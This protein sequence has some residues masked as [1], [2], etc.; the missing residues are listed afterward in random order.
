MAARIKTSDGENYIIVPIPTTMNECKVY[1]DNI[2]KS[3]KKNV[4]ALNADED[5]AALQGIV[6]AFRA[7]YVSLFNAR[8]GNIDF[9]KSD[10][11]FLM[12]DASFSISFSSC[13][14]VRTQ[15]DGQGTSQH[16]S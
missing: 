11:V 3:I 8:K 12:F 2:Y 13:R 7:F 4:C 15:A 5:L 16:R 9:S 1:I 10:V 6:D 14:C